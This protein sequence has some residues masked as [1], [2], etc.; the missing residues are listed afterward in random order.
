MT[1]HLNGV[2]AVQPVAYPTVMIDGELYG[3]KFTLGSWW[4]LKERGIDVAKLGDYIAAENA[5]GRGIELLFTLLS[6]SLGQQHG[7]VWR[8]IGLSPMELADQ[9]LPAQYAELNS[10]VSQALSKAPEPAE[11]APATKNQPATDSTLM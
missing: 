8:S 6:C 4:R 7:K 1:P 11:P 9:L 10:A 5:A 3:I 2:A